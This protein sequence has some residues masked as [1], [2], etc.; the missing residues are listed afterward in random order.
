M[1]NVKTLKKGNKINARYLPNKLT[2]K[3]KVAQLRMLNKSRKMY[4]TSKP[5]HSRKIYKN[6]ADK[7]TRILRTTFGYNHIGISSN[8]K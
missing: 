4:K 1:A 7:A 8:N 2:K 6:I 3:D 5:T